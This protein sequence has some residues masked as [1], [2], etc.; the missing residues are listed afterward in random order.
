[1]ISKGRISPVPKKLS[2]FPPCRTRTGLGR[3]VRQ[4]ANTRANALLILRRVERSVIATSGGTRNRIGSLASIL[5][6]NVASASAHLRFAVVSTSRTPRCRETDRRSVSDRPGVIDAM[7]VDLER[8]KA[9]D[10]RAFATLVEPFRRELQL[11]CYRLLGS[12]QDAEDLVQETLLAAWRG[13]DGF[14]ERASLRS[15]LYR[16][17][18]NRSLNAIRERGRRPATENIMRPSKTRRAVEPSWLEP[19]PD[20]ALPDPAPGPETRYEQR[21]AIQLSFIV[22]LQQLP[23]KQRAALVLRD[24]LGFHTGEAAAILETTA[25]S[26]KAA[27]QRARATLDSYTLEREQAPLPDSPTERSLLA[28]FSDAVE[29]GDTARLLTLLGSDARVTM[30]PQPFELIGHEAIGGFLDDRAEGRGAP[31]QLPP[32]PANGPAALRSYP[33]SQPRG[34]MVLTLSGNSVQEITFFDDPALPGRFG[35]PEHI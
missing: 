9:G 25:Q 5:R 2:A 30:P 23:A 14:E 35:L 1:M 32:T 13:L 24:V 34:M 11:H 7:T 17:A 20:S 18:T 31:L 3:P 21:E 22:A 16:I 33:R 29:A 15:W 28:T 6:D 10:E 8:A 27:L 12:V 19:Y 26:V 4:T